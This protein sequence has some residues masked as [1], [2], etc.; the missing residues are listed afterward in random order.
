MNSLLFL[1]IWIGSQVLQVALTSAAYLQPRPPGGGRQ[2]GPLY[3]S[4][5]ASLVPLITLVL[6]LRVFVIGGSS[7]VAQIA[8]EAG[9]GLWS[10]WASAWL[11]LFCG[12][13]IVFVVLLVAAMR[14]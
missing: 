8:G 1:F 4:T 10:L 7:N 6:F 11:P 14:P 2:L 5:A 13:P 9:M 12:I 3:V